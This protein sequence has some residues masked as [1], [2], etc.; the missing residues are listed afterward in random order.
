[1]GGRFLAI[2]LVAIWLS[3]W[4]CAASYYATC[5]LFTILSIQGVTLPTFLSVLGRSLPAGLPTRTCGYLVSWPMGA[6]LMAVWLVA[7]WLM[8][9]WPCAPS[10]FATTLNLLSNLIILPTQSNVA[11]ALY[12]AARY[13]QAYSR[14]PAD[15]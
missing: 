9:L 13:P 4:S 5:D 15:I 1:M 12:R 8:S 7:I 2:R 6:R 3:I 10:Y 11:R 14:A